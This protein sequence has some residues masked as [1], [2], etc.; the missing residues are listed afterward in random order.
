VFGTLVIQL[1]SNYE[2]G[3]LNVYHKE[4]ESEFSFSGPTATRN[5]YFAAF[6]AD[7]EHEVKPVTKGYCLCLIYNLIYTGMDE[8]PAPAD[9]SKEVSALVSA[10]EAW[11]GDV[12]SGDCPKMMTYM[13]K[14]QY[15]E[16]GLSFQSLKNVDRAVGDVL[17]QVKG[18]VDFDLYLANVH[19][20]EF[21]TASRCDGLYD[22]KTEALEGIHAGAVHP[23][24]FDGT[25]LDYNVELDTE[26]FVPQGFFQTIKPD[27]ENFQEATGNEEASVDKHYSWAG[28]LIWPVKKRT[29][30][31]HGT[32]LVRDFELEVKKSNGAAD[33][34]EFAED[35][36]REVR[37]RCSMHCERI[38]KA[39]LQM[40]NRDLV[41]RCLDI[42]SEGDRTYMGQSFS[43][44]VFSIS[45]KYGWEILKSPLRTI[46]A[47][48]TPDN[49]EAYCGF[50]MRISLSQ[51]DDEQKEVCQCLAAVFVNCLVTEQDVTPSSE[52]YIQSR[53]VWRLTWGGELGFGS[54]IYRSKEFVCG[55]VRVLNTLG[56]TD[57][58]IAFVDALRSKPALYPVLETL[59]PGVVE[60]G[61]TF[62]IEKE[63]P[64]Y[65]LLLYC[66]TTLKA[67]LREVMEPPN[68]TRSV[69]LPCNC[70]DCSSL[71][72]FMK[73]PDER[74]CRIQVDRRRRRHLE[75]QLRWTSEVTYG[76]D[77]SSK[78]HALVILKSQTSA[79][80]NKKVE[81]RQ[82]EQSLFN[83]LRALLLSDQNKQMSKKVKSRKSSSKN[84]ALF[85]D[86]DEP[87]KVTFKFIFCVFLF[88]FII[89]I[90]NC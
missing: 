67:S 74:S 84:S 57:L 26:L 47:K 23:M 1:P 22:Y 52:P 20:I 83:E 30:V 73:H 11:N 25:T 55:L 5:F 45:H 35:V 81:K 15:C 2:G 63:G 64:L 65:E 69:C 68:Y 41:V 9:N 87:C 85:K 54:E 62:K 61:K 37:G 7:C 31:K 70:E 14:H 36:L 90:Q 56:C 48:C 29:A 80:Y 79:G 34:M 72:E 8:C 27:K 3:Q 12:E 53:S 58:L 44:V 50:L 4:K 78:P 13:L 88:I 60:I 66:A 24:A 49:V 28:L 18:E 82:K 43:D 32:S 39:F 86:T 19:L 59:G 10:I 6:Y 33:V 77:R 51:L 89:N 46:F 40:D 76:K 21:W 38:L 42:I 71:E 75:D 16:A 17:L